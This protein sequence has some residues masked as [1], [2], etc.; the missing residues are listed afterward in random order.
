MSQ[1]EAEES[2]CREFV[3]E[4]NRLAEHERYRYVG[5]LSELGGKHFPEFL[6]KDR[7][8][9]KELHVECARF[10]PDWD[11]VERAN[12]QILEQRIAN[13]LQHLGY[14]NRD[15]I[16]QIRNPDKHPLQKLNRSGV[17]DLARSIKK[18]LADK[19]PKTAEQSLTQF[20]LDEFPRYAPMAKVFQFLLLTK[21]EVVGHLDDASPGAR[22]GVIGYEATEI[23]QRLAET[24]S[25]KLPGQADI[26]LIYSEGPLFLLDVSKT[27]IRLNEIAEVRQARQSFGEIW[28]LAHYW[29]GDQKLYR[30]V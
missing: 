10:G 20:N 15:I 30:I 19:K 6:V 2:K 17:E 23:D 14:E 11:T 9:S 1:K 4:L 16:L 26:L 5:H 18:F 7:R 12:L 21:S 8:T 25:G 27:V 13:D 29:A 24:I 22:L 3:D 28:F